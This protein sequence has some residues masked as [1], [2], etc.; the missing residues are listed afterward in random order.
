MAQSELAAVSVPEKTTNLHVTKYPAIITDK[1][2]LAFT[3]I[4]H[5][6]ILKAAVSVSPAISAASTFVDLSLF[7]RASSDSRDFSTPK[8]QTHNDQSARLAHSVICFIASGLCS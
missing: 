4:A 3:D 2:L 8:Q 1:T 5:E 6:K 7:R